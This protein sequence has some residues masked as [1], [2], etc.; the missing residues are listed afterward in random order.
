MARNTPHPKIVSIPTG[1][2]AERLGLRPG[3]CLVSINDMP[4]RDKID[5]MFYAAEP[6]HSIEYLRAGKIYKRQPSKHLSLA[7]DLEDMQPRACGNQCV[8]CFVHQLPRGLRRSLYFKDE[9]YRFSFLYGNYITATN[10]KEEDF[11]RIAQQRLSPLCISIHATNPAVRNALLGNPRAPAIMPILRRLQKDNIQ[12]HAQI[13]LIPGL[14]DGAVLEETLADLNSFIS[15]NPTDKESEYQPPLLSIAIVPVG[16]TDHRRSLP[17]LQRV[18]PQYAKAF[19]AAMEKKQRAMR[20]KYGTPCLFLSDEFYLLAGL[21]PP[22]YRGWEEIPQLGNG[23]GLTAYFYRGFN[24]AA[25]LLPQRLKRPTRL[26]LVTG[27]LGAIVLKKLCERLNQVKNLR[28]KILTVQNT[29]LGK[30]ITVAGL[31][32]AGDIARTIFAN[33]KFDFYMLPSECLNTEGLT[34]DGAAPAQIEK[35]TGKRIIVAPPRCLDV[36][37]IIRS[38]NVS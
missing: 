16:L 7:L 2:P 27:P 20:Q 21:K 19:V 10:L 23:V 12:F 29:L 32:T 5:F 13:V 24:R 3:D 30:N 8:F 37:E 11:C 25:H 26:A 36:I 28:V 9:D 4:I 34:L 17:P 31:M 14:N 6:I 35:K 22:S 15:Q 1:S 18:S 33:P 38:L